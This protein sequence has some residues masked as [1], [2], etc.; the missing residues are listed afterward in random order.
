MNLAP[1]NAD[2]LA[3]IERLGASVD[4]RLSS[5]EG[6][7][8]SVDTRL[9]SVEKT[10]KDTNAVINRMDIRLKSVE[11]TVDEILVSTG[12]NSKAIGIIRAELEALEE[13]VKKLENA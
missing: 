11:A 7:L 10:G 8:S 2:L 4:T 13:R 5:F 6:R 9:S 12:M 1:T 3:A